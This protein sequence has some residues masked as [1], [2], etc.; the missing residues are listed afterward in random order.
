MQ[1]AK[2]HKSNRF[3]FNLH[4]FFIFFLIVSIIA[5]S[6]YL[7][8]LTNLGNSQNSDPI[9]DPVEIR[10]E[11]KPIQKWWDMKW[12]NAFRI[13]LTNPSYQESKKGSIAQFSFN[14]KE[15]V[16]SGKSK[17]KGEDLRLI[18]QNE[19]NELFL[20]NFDFEG[21]NTESSRIIF[22][23]NESLPKR[24]STGRHFLYY[25]NLVPEGSNSF[26]VSKNTNT[27]KTELIA[28]IGESLNPAFN[29]N[30]ARKWFLKGADLAENYKIL[31]ADIEVN[32]VYGYEDR[33]ALVEVLSTDLKSSSANIKNNKASIKFDVS[34][35]APGSYKLKVQIDT[36]QDFY[37]FKVSFP[38]YAT[39]TM[40]WEGY[41]VK[42]QYLADL[43]E[44]S[45]GNGMP[46]THY[47]NPRIYVTPTIS[48][49]RRAYLTNWVKDRKV[50][51]GDEIS[52]HLHMHFDI[53][54]AAGVEKRL[55]VN[56]SGNTDGYDV[57]TASYLPDE[58]EKIVSFGLNKFKENGLSQ[59]IGYRAGGWFI[60]TE[61][62]K[63][64]PKLGFK[65]D[66]S[67]R[68]AYTFGKNKV[69]GLWN[70]KSTTKP[71]KIS[72]A[73]QNSGKA[74][75]FNLW[76]FPNNGSESTNLKGE[77]MLKRLNDN[78]KGQP[79]EDKQVITFLSHP[80]WFN[81]DKPKMQA[82]FLEM[83]K[84]KAESGNGPVI[85]TTLEKAYTIYTK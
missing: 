71:Y 53:V 33:I 43:D 76:Q 20:L 34:D 18:Y 16:E 81:G 22:D 13:K 77:E 79:L 30:I 47:F 48:E 73:D 58:F 60:N 64:L 26:I 21:A 50:S 45:N 19:E 8:N 7:Y 62:L 84:F 40:D 15:L 51:R 31:N 4:N 80:H 85:Y 28:E 59:P 69:K 83:N 55:D 54:E 65:Y 66:S 37:D 68:E 74:P 14:H 25:S 44:L 41:D 10:I 78:F 42:D 17:D 75:T 36:Y 11:A 61:N 9:Q 32:P 82:L 38:L 49:A 1:L 6:F 52:M 12:K 29:L 24:F 57:L 56:W 2:S 5:A 23:L 63:V 3:K 72:L 67:G 46:I 70:L 39:W 27:V 35:L